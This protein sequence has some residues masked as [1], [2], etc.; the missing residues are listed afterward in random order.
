MK[1]FADDKVY[2][3]LK[4]LAFLF[5]EGGYNIPQSI[6]KRALKRALDMTDEDKDEFI[7]FEDEKEIDFFRTVKY[8]VNFDDYDDM[9]KAEY[10]K[11]ILSSYDRLTDIQDR[12]NN[13]KKILEYLG[14]KSKYKRESYKITS[15]REIDKVK[16][17]EKTVEL[18][19]QFKPKKRSLFKR[20][21]G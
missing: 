5:K 14:N 19:I 3:Q 20:R 17:G 11:F 8:I 15:I 4:D 9:T 6:Y 16:K 1:I 7:V 12:I 21:N 18:P 2:V 10:R 13:S